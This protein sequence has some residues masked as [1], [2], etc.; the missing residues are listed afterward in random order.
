MIEAMIDSRVARGEWSVPGNTFAS[1]VQVYIC[2]IEIK[3]IL[4]S[5]HYSQLKDLLDL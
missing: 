1:A 4:M 3:V 5:G 2:C